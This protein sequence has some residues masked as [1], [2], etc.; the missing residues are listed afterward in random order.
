M[1]SEYFKVRLNRWLKNANMETTV[2]LQIHDRPTESRPVAS[3]NQS[4][5]QMTQPVWIAT[6]PSYCCKVH[7]RLVFAYYKL[8]G[9]TASDVILSVKYIF[10]SGVLMKLRQD[11]HVTTV[12]S[13][14]LTPPLLHRPPTVQQ[15]SNTDWEATAMCWWRSDRQT[16]SF[17]SSS[18]SLTDDPPSIPLSYL[19][20]DR[21]LSVVWRL[22]VPLNTL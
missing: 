1:W 8:R 17:S 21:Q 18:V 20:T 16:S 6:R 12:P 15:A 5:M 10:G 14:T 2:A 11:G 22:N 9:C 19:H 3:L 7:R 13:P 4:Q